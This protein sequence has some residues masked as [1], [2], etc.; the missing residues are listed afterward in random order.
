MERFTKE[1]FRAQDSPEEILFGEI[2]WGKLFKGEGGTIFL[3][4]NTT[5]CILEKVAYL[6]KY[7]LYKAHA[8]KIYD[9]KRSLDGQSIYYKK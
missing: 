8:D 7:I 9:T 2:H 6:E 1:Y 4:F 3:T 5:K